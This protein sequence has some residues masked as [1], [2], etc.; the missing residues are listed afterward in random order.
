MVLWAYASYAATTAGIERRRHRPPRAFIATATALI[1]LT[2]A[3]VIALL[4]VEAL[5]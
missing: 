4:A 3:V 5:D 1:A 2:G